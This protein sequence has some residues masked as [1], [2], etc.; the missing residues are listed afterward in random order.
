MLPAKNGKGDNEN[1][2]RI[3]NVALFHHTRTTPSR[4]STIRHGW[5][6]RVDASRCTCIVTDTW[7][8]TA[9]G[10]CSGE[11]AN[12][13]ACPG[14]DSP[15]FRPLVSPQREETRRSIQKDVVNH[16]RIYSCISFTRTLFLPSLPSVHF[17]I[18]SLTLLTCTNTKKVLLLSHDQEGH[19]TVRRTV[20]WTLNKGFWVAIAI[21]SLADYSGKENSLYLCK[22]MFERCQFSDALSIALLFHV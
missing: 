18:A 20:K 11:Y 5:M 19:L 1:R 14:S 9:T 7:C 2:P 13:R 8:I 17:R 3:Y 10:L 16:A 22:V 21:K 12:Q 4:V 6:H 15:P